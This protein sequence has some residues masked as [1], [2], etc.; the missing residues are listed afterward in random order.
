MGPLT[1]GLWISESALVLGGGKGGRR[2]CK[3]KQGTR[4]TG[5]GYFAR[6]VQ[7]EELFLK[8]PLC[9]VCWRLKR[10]IGHANC[11]NYIGILYD[12][13]VL[14]RACDA[15]PYQ[16]N[17]FSLSYHVHIHSPYI[18]SHTMEFM[19]TYMASKRHDVG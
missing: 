17:F 11:F 18:V 10:Y 19:N 7:E 4:E 12:S 16:Q 13:S 14:T 6:V 15:L 8:A 9:Y 2:K 3:W 1:L 5:C